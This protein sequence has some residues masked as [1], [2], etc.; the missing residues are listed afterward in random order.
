M[1][2]TI[3]IVYIL[4]V[5]CIIGSIINLFVFIMIIKNFKNGP[6]N[7]GKNRGHYFI[8]LQLFIADFL[9]CFCNAIAF[10]YNATNQQND[11]YKNNYMCKFQ[12][13]CGI[14]FASLSILLMFLI[15]Y[16]RYVAIVINRKLSKCCLRSISLFVWIVSCMLG[17]GLLSPQLSIIQTPSLV[18]CSTDWSNSSDMN[19]FYSCVCVSILLFS[20]IAT[21]HFYYRIHRVTYESS[22]QVKKMITINHTTNTAN[23]TI[24]YRML[25]L[26]ILFIFGWS[27]YCSMIFYNL[28]TH[29]I[30]SANYDIVATMLS[31][32]N[33]TLNPIVYLILNREKLISNYKNENNDNNKKV[34]LVIVKEKKEMMNYEQKIINDFKNSHVNNLDIDFNIN[35]GDNIHIH[36]IC[37]CINFENNNDDENEKDDDIWNMEDNP[38][39]ISM[40]EN[41]H[42]DNNYII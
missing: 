16:D 12:G 37:C 20:L 42:L 21:T 10:L 28:I 39:D 29:Q 36:I 30:S 13:V 19:I 24:A 26:I 23:T 9:L 38:Y 32:L 11:E 41:E 34:R 22:Q 25:T 31:F 15:S 5:L 27:T 17:F 14:L 33:S 8:L 18:F 35:D 6:G 40:N 7:N 1:S 4:F 2:I 3:I